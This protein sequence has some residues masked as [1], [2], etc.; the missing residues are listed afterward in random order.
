MK[1]KKVEKLIKESTESI[2]SAIRS[3]KNNGLIKVILFGIV[4]Y[5]YK[6]GFFESCPAAEQLVGLLIEITN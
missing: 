1:E 4:C 6:N 5:M 2:I 3:I